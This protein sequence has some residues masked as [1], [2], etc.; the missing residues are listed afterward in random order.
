LTVA[1]RNYPEEPF[2]IYGTLNTG[3]FAKLAPL[4]IGNPLR[5]HV[6]GLLNNGQFRSIIVTRGGYAEVY[7]LDDDGTLLVQREQQTSPD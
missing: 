3:A 7:S 2:K 1:G 4:Q 6:E 5:A